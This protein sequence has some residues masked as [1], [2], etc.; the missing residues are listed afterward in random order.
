M[1]VAHSKLLILGLCVVM[2]MSVGTGCKKKPKPI[3]PNLTTDTGMN[4]NSGFEET[5]GSGLP[6]IDTGTLF[7]KATEMEVVYFDYNSSALRPDALNSLKR[8][9]EIMKQNPTTLYQIE[10]HCDERGTQEYNLALGERRALSVREY[11][12]RLGVSGDRVITISYGEEMPAVMGSGESAWSKNRRC[13]FN[14]STRP[15]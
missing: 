7:E 6:E 15:Q 5:T 11:L 13:E 3:D 14:K 4:N 2:T 9:A 1:K 8:N 10:G 12:T